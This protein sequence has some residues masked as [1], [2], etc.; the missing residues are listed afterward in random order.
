MRSAQDRKGWLIL[1][2]VGLF[3]IVVF[4]AY[5]WRKSTRPMVGSDNCVYLD[6][7]LLRR[8]VVD[9]TVI[10]IDQSEALSESHKRQVKEKLISYIADD[11]QLRVG[12]VVMLYVFGKNDFEKAGVGQKLAPIP[13]LCKP[14]SSGN[15]VI[16][17]NRKIAKVFHDRF[18]MPMYA[19]IER[20]MDV[21]LGERSPILEMIQY[22]SRSQDVKESVGR[23]QKKTLIVVSDLLQHSES[24]SHYRKWTYDDFLATSAGALR[25]DLRGWNIHVLYLQRYGRD[26]RMQDR[27][28]FAFWERYFHDAGGKLV[29]ADRIP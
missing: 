6:K 26:Q 24:F 21:A 18:V 12:S 14:P 22:V 15:E 3:V 29:A 13:L 16:E 17:N 10:I 8:Q 23:A 27:E 28:H 7:Q 5:L 1:A 25:T 11:D 20:S 9:Q 2:L 19:A 4:G